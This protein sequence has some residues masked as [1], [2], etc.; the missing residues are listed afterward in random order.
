MERTMVREDVY[1]I[2]II[3]A[4]HSGMSC[5]YELHKL[6]V[7]NFVVIE[8]RDRVGGRTVT[9]DLGGGAWADGG[10]QWIGPM[11]T[12]VHAL[13]DELEAEKFPF[14]HTGKVWF[15]FDGR[16]YTEDAVPAI[17]GGT[18]RADEIMAMAST[19][20]LDAPWLAPNA[21]KWDNM[22]VADW[23][24]DV[25]F[26]PEESAQLGLGAAIS[27][28]GAPE[29]LSLLYYLYFA[30]S[31]GSIEALE[32]AEGGAQETRITGGTQTLSLKI[33]GIIG[34]DKIQLGNPVRNVSNWDGDGPVTIETARGTIAAREVV[35]AMSPALVGRIAFQPAL[36][37][38]RA[39]LQKEWPTYAKL[40]KVHLK[41]DRPFWREDG[42]SGVT[43]ADY[44]PARL[45]V[46]NSPADASCGIILIFWE[47]EL[48][49]TQEE[50]MKQAA[51]V[52]AE[53]LGPK[54]LNP[55]GYVVKDWTVDEWSEGC[56]S[57]L[58]PGVLTKYGAALR[59]PVGHIVWA[60]TEA[61]EMNTNSIDGAV[62][63][64]QAAGIRAAAALAG[65]R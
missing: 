33:A 15:D 39:M 1:D 56:V 2:A 45:T 65:S 16:R 11:Q 14:Y 8:A 12:A 55:T 32:S 26:T 58:G 64:G 41:Y 38:K 25:G 43:C 59:E 54:A 24:R 9:Q 28:G 49:A 4:G 36:P 7:R 23:M 22:T 31:S 3:G 21:A 34:H 6:G 20:P 52:M 42:W 50:Q 62:R 40:I 57:P 60:G 37:E 27:N 30:R 19:V 61:A 10:G 13:A 5:A 53:R 44:P 48:K 46:D 17:A 35:I 18:P 29:Q 51:T 47:G 63:A